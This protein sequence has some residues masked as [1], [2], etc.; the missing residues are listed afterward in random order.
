M[1]PPVKQR[2]VRGDWAEECVWRLPDWTGFALR[3]GNRFSSYFPSLGLYRAGCV[4]CL[5]FDTYDKGALQ[6]T[7]FHS[8]VCIYVYMV[9]VW[10]ATM[11]R[12]YSITFG[13]SEVGRP[14]ANIATASSGFQRGRCA[15]T[16]QRG[17]CTY[18]RNR[19]AARVGNSKL[20]LQKVLLRGLV[21]AIGAMFTTPRVA[22]CY[23]L[24]AVS[25]VA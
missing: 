7:E 23:P 25:E 15:R 3:N 8:Q 1:E 24:S 18:R 6:F 14:R 19:V 13:N 4:L 11:Y 20:T 17:L 10:S 16:N 22:G 12:L 2:S 5:I 21:V 9:T